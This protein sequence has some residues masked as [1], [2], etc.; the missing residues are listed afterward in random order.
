MI[1]R[2]A[3]AICW[4]HNR[5]D[6]AFSNI[7]VPTLAAVAVGVRHSTR[8]LFML[9]PTWV[10]SVSIRLEAHRVCATTHSSQTEK[11]QTS[12]GHGRT[13][14]SSLMN[15]CSPQVGGFG[16]ART[17]TEGHLNKGGVVCVFVVIMQIGMHT[18]QDSADR[19]VARLFPL[20]LPNHLMRANRLL[21]SLAGSVGLDS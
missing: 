3:N 20:H 9:R 10:F 16:C 18:G 12:G 6:S 13:V 7:F 15:I 19:S 1:H 4:Q 8:S 2:S 5:G 17:C 21:D 14:E 11:K